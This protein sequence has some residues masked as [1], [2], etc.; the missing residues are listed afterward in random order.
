M[1]LLGPEDERA[2]ALRHLAFVGGSWPAEL[3]AGMAVLCEEQLA[4]LVGKDPSRPY[5][6]GNPAVVRI[7]ADGRRAAEDARAGCAACAR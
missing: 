2:A 4:E 6:P 7:T 1:K 3:A 5:G